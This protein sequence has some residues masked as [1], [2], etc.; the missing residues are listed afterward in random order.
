ME[1][2]I[3]DLTSTVRAVDGN[4]L[5]TPELMRQIVETVLRAVREQEEHRARVRAEQ[6]ITSGVRGELEAE[7]E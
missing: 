2:Y 6:R 4:S 3:G 1:I 5:L 7:T